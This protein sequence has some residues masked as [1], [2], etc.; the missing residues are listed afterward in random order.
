MS[1]VNSRLSLFRALTAQLLLSVGKNV[2]QTRPVLQ[3]SRVLAEAS[4]VTRVA[5]AQAN[6]HA[7]PTERHEA[8]F[9]VGQ[10]QRKGSALRQFQLQMT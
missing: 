10:G 9:S 2:F 3:E 6:G 1:E 4:R 8:T 7:C 5:Q